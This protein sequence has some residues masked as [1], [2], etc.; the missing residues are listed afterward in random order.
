MRRHTNI[1]VTIELTVTRSQERLLRERAQR[2]MLDNNHSDEE[3]AE[4]LD[5]AKK[6]LGDCAQI[7][8]DIGSGGGDFDIEN[9]SNEESVEDGGPMPEEHA[10]VAAESGA[11]I[12]G[13]EDGTV[14][15]VIHVYEDGERGEVEFEGVG[16]RT[17]RAD[18]IDFAD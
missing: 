2:N 13:V 11:D 4:Y 16:V 8:L 7:I 14:G 9:S 17:V 10:V 5:P 3:A 18:Q 6:S 1:S 15:T 12:E